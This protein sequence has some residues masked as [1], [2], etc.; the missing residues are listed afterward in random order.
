MIAPFSDTI[1]V[2]LKFAIA[3]AATRAGW[4]LSGLVH[5]KWGKRKP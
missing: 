2:L 3:I 4:H 5:D 1:G